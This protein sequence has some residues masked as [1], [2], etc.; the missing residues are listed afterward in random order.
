MKQSYLPQ[1]HN[2]PQ[3]AGMAAQP[4]YYHAQATPYYQSYERPEYGYL[5]AGPGLPAA[6]ANG[7]GGWFDFSNAGYLKGFLVGAGA[8]LLLTNPTIQKALVRGTVKLW[9]LLQGGME[10]V[11]EQFRDV[12]AEMSEEK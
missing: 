10:E 4:Q 1:G 12:Q 11:K 8:T 3:T 6:S 9:T 2:I 5:P 7:L